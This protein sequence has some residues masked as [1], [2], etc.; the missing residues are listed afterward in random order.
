MFFIFHLQNFNI[1]GLITHI[2]ISNVNFKSLTLNLHVEQK[3][4]KSL[5]GGCS[6]YRK[7]FLHG[8]SFLQ[9]ECCLVQRYTC[10]SRINLK[11]F[12]RKIQPQK[13]KIII[14]KLVLVGL[15]FKVMYQLSPWF[16]STK[17]VWPLACFVS[18]QIKLPRLR[19]NFINF[20][21][22]QASGTSNTAFFFEK[23]RIFS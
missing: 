9:E 2:I 4:F 6:F 17:W 10:I 21:W 18:A 22:F 3:C 13:S 5:W 23:G 14:L 19:H 12:Y 7:F 16:L 20:I 8:K 1:W 15:V 11:S